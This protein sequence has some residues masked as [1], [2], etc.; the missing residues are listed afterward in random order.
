L[1]QRLKDK[2]F[3][4]TQFEQEWQSASTFFNLIRF[5]YSGQQKILEK[6]YLWRE[7]KGLRLSPRLAVYRAYEEFCNEYYREN[8][9]KKDSEADFIEMGMALHGSAPF[10]DESGNYIDRENL[11]IPLWQNYHKLYL[12]KRQK[13]N[14]EKE[15]RSN[16]IMS[17]RF[18]PEDID[19]GWHQ[20]KNGDIPDDALTIW[21]C[22]YPRLSGHTI[23][24]NA[25]VSLRNLAFWV[26]VFRKYLY[27]IVNFVDG[28]HMYCRPDKHQT[29]GEA[30]MLKNAAI[31]AAFERKNRKF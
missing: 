9:G 5:H 11:L 21:D 31:L 23:A 7:Q 24:K 12:V 27:F 30:I 28:T 8:I 18:S 29:L 15:A 19:S 20:L 16:E 13:E 14:V 4:K 22:S 3:W 10:V 1:F 26:C 6:K 25:G 2:I 17:F